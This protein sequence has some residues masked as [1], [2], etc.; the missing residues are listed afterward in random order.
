MVRLK[1]IKYRIKLCFQVLF[2]TI[3]RTISILVAVV[4]IPGAAASIVPNTILFPLWLL[5]LWRL[6]VRT[7]SELKK[8]NECLN[9][10]CTRG[11]KKIINYY[12]QTMALTQHSR[13][14]HTQITLNISFGEKKNE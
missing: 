14:S 6:T 4:K 11:G 13:Q 8:K 2:S 7:R 1:T 5:R 3:W 9:M 12:H 10:L